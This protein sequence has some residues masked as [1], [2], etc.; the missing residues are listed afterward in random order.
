MS[1]HLP[2]VRDPIDS[3]QA[4]AGTDSTLCVSVTCAYGMDVSWQ[5]Q[6]HV[7]HHQSVILVDPPPAQPDFSRIAWHSLFGVSVLRLQLCRD[8]NHKKSSLCRNL[9]SLWS[10]WAVCRLPLP[11]CRLA[12][13]VCRLPQTGIPYFASLWQSTDCHRLEFIGIQMNAQTEK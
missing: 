2:T 7:G 12:N 8:C 13:A 4:V 11:I 10:L 9:H 3:L 6:T 5:P 1:I